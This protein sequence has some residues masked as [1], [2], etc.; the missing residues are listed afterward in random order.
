MKSVEWVVKASKFCNLRCEYCYEW[1]SLG[2]PERISLEQWASVLEGIR[3]YHA[4]LE[5]RVGATHEVRLIWHGGEP[6]ALPAQYLDRAMALQHDILDGLPHAI[7]LQTNLYRLPANTLDVLRQRDVRLGVSMDVF[8]GVRRDVGGRE[9]EAAVVA[10]MDHL[11][12]RGIRYGAITVVAKHNH[13][14]LREVH[15]FWARRGVGF[16]VLPLFEGPAERPAGRFELSDAELVEALNDLFDHWIETGAIVDVV[17]LSEWLRD[18]LR[19]RLGVKRAVYNRRRD[20]ERVFLVETN[21]DLYQTDERGRPELSLGNLLTE[22]MEAILAGRAFAESLLRTDAKAA[23]YCGGC[24]H[25]GFC[26]GYP[27]HAEPFAVAPQSGCPVTSAVHDHIDDYLHDA[28]YDRA[29]LLDLL[30][31]AEVRTA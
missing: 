23:Q 24:R 5:Q 1:N 17:P 26:D 25:Y 11:E 29:A 28:G 18:A 16:R 27:V 6:L 20:G 10:N 9:T 14:R 3:T 8:G 31:E 30:A 13:R 15:D 4:M 19:E 21:G 7:L 22:S 12:Q 2:N